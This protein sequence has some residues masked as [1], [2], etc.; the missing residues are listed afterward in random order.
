M[1]PSTLSPSARRGLAIVLTV[2]MSI[3]WASNSPQAFGEHLLTTAGGFLLM[4]LLIYCSYTDLTRK[5]I[6]N[7]ATYTALSGALVFN[8][9]SSL[10][11]GTTDLAAPPHVKVNSGGMFESFGAIGII[12]SGL[13]ALACFGAMLIIYS[14]SRTGA[15]DVK[16]ATAI[17]AFV[18]AENGLSAILWCH[19]LAGIVAI[20]WL[21]WN[22][23]LVSIIRTITRHLGSEL[24]PTLVF[25]PTAKSAKVLN[26]PI[27]LAAFF[28]AGTILALCGGAF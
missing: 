2:V 1:I 24:F 5:R 18:G 14:V 21:A 25:P 9:A 27:P 20:V 17:G 6:L 11:A 4:A 3:A 13:G 28:A 7:W 19:L 23:G 10:L 15:G 22:L 26:K 8:A 12:S 16:L